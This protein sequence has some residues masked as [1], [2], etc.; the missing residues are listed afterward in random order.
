MS[1][2]NVSRRGD[3]S[4][5]TYTYGLRSSVGENTG[6]LEQ[7]YTVTPNPALIQSLCQKTDAIVLRA[8]NGEDTGSELADNGK[9][10]YG[11][12]FPRG[13]V[14]VSDLA[15]RLHGE[16]PLL[17]CSN[18]AQVPWELLHNGDDFLSLRHDLGRKTF[19]DQRVVSG[20][21][22]GEL[23]R[24]LIV[25]DPLGDLDA[26]REEAGR[27]ADWLGSHG[28]ECTSL[29]GREA[30][31]VG[32]V[33]ILDAGDYDLFHYSGHVDTPYD[34]K[35]TGLR[36]HEDQ[37]LDERALQPL[38]NKGVP[39][40]VFINGC[41]SA[42]QLSNL[43]VA[44]M[45]TGAKVVIGT[46]YKVK[47]ESARQFAESFYDTML[48]GKTAGA[49]VREARQSLARDGGIDWASFVL[50]GD[51]SAVITVPRPGDTGAGDDTGETIAIVPE[52]SLDPQASALMQRVQRQAAP[53]GIATSLDLLTELIPTREFRGR[54]AGTA[55]SANLSVLQ[56]LL[57]TVQDTTPPVPAAA[58]QPIE[59]SGTVQSVL[60][61]ATRRVHES[62]RGLVTIDDLVD[63]F[64]AVGGGHSREILELMGVS[65]PGGSPGPGYGR[66]PANGSQGTRS[67]TVEAV[68]RG[69][70]HSLPFGA[71]GQ[72]RRDSL[73]PAATS[74]LLVAMLLAAAQGAV[75]STSA[76]LAAFAVAN[77][78]ALR[79]SFADQGAAGEA[80]FA[81]LSS[82]ARPSQR[83]F[84]PRT[85][86][87]LRRAAE[88]A[89]R[90]ERVDDAGILRELLAEEDSA[91][92]EALSRLNLDP[93]QVLRSLAPPEQAQS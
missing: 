28:T 91:A 26:A 93:A 84:S 15:Q 35:L 88:G 90:G 46:R 12:L 1:Q 72:L 29:L 76:L 61:R 60:D 39:P 78:D 45:I 74:A 19:V 85:L 37:L 55:R 44:F 73:T 14:N 80:A 75:V 86:R 24:A 87:A 2:L 22:V 4:S 8:Q 41:A 33:Q 67:V 10:L 62:G 66:T 42:G 38:S 30:T 7:E 23:K 51:P 83:H 71:D 3:G 57:S 47:E 70:A 11:T 9:L 18:E 20:R 52:T 5:V 68:N 56:H 27:I 59:L 64:F 79:E 53:H 92:R 63:A 6:P 82:S 36:L 34:S 43:C 49:A 50:Y 21:A 77:S 48:A 54:V 40:I 31:L 81:K 16:D 69:G 13:H 58:D 65:M 25:G 17:V 32:V 89:A